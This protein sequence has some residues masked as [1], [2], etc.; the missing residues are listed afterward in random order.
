MKKLSAKFGIAHSVSA[1]LNLGV[2][3]AAIAHSSWLAEYGS[4]L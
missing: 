3:I 2:M 4:G 1:L